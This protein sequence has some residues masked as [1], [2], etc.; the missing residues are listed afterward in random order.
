[1][2]CVPA[3]SFEVEKT[4]FPW[5]TATE[6]RVAEPSLKFTVPACNSPAADVTVA[7][8][9]TSCPTFEG[10]REEISATMDEDLPTTWINGF[11]LLAAEFGSPRYTAVI[12]SEPTGRLGVVRLALPSLN[13]PVPSTAPPFMNVTV[14]PSGIGESLEATA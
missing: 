6:P 12:E 10:F 8:K 3:A 9:F 13:I 2:G 5:L 11:D 1:M 4:A 14:S 7:V